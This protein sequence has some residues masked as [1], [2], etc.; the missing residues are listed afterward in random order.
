MRTL[1]SIALVAAALAGAT[2]ARAASLPEL[3]V[4]ASYVAGTPLEVRCATTYEEYE[5][6]HDMGPFFARL[7]LGYTDLTEPVVYL[8]P[9]ACLPLLGDWRSDPEA[10]GAAVLVITHESVHQRGIANELWTECLALPLV[11]TVAVQL[12]VPWASLGTI[13]GAALRQHNRL[14]AEYRG[15]CPARMPL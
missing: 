7:F 13:R 11:T 9:R 1:I 6:W 10:F 15:T 12:G 14:G 2:T 5:T 8:S 4:A 3:E